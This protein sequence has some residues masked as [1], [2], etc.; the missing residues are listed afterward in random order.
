VRQTAQV[1]TVGGEIYRA[2]LD[3]RLQEEAFGGQRQLQQAA[4]DVHF[5][6]WARCRR[7]APPGRAGGTCS[8]S[9]WTVTS[10]LSLPSTSLTS[11]GIWIEF[12]EHDP[13][14][15]RFPVQLLPE[16]V[17]ADVA[18]QDGDL[19]PGIRFLISRAFLIA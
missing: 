10:T 15:A 16:A 2:Q 6:A 5:L 19:R 13:G 7:S 4:E 11:G 3:V 14:L 1:N 18:V 9:G 12:Q 17:A 8:P